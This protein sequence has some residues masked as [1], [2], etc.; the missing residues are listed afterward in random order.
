VPI[1]EERLKKE[2]D[3]PRYSC[4]TLPVSEGVYKERFGRPTSYPAVEDTLKRRKIEAWSK[5]DC[6]YSG[7]EM[8]SLKLRFDV[9]KCRT[10]NQSNF[11]R[12]DS[13]AS[14]VLQYRK[15]RG[16]GGNR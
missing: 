2:E 10:D 8:R 7:V 6:M 1:L 14:N 12:A 15:Y 9:V 11:V 13:K 4:A 5:S 3:T 16:K